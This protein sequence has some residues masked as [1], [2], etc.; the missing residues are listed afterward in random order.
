MH[1]RNTL[2]QNSAPTY[3]IVNRDPIDVRVDEIDQH[4]VSGLPDKVC[5][6]ALPH[7][8]YPEDYNFAKTLL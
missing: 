7:R 2:W 6:Q 1:F 3:F 8:A 5:A 4:L